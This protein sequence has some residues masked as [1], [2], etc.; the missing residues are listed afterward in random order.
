MSCRSV[1]FPCSSSL[2]L[3]ACLLGQHRESL[4]SWPAK[5]NQP[6]NNSKNPVLR[7]KWEKN[8]EIGR[9][10]QCVSTYRHLQACRCI[11]ILHTTTTFHPLLCCLLGAHCSNSL[12]TATA[13]TCGCTEDVGEGECV[14]ARAGW[15]QC[16]HTCVCRE[17]EQPSWL[18]NKCAYSH[19][20]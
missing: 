8:L 7:T 4:L 14:C 1:F 10:S 2:S 15:T 12:G 3:Y 19:R 18:M 5:S 6:K 13:A 9:A 20:Y 11:P 16:L 17:N